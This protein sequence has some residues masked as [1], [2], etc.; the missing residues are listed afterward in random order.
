MASNPFDQFDKEVE[1]STGGANPFDKFDEKELTVG[2][3][4]ELLSRGAA[5]V[6]TGAV[7]G[8]PFGA[9]GSLV[10]SMAVPIGDALNTI[11]NELSKGNAAVENYIRGLVGVEQTAKPIQLPMVSTLVSKGMEKVG[12]GAEPTTTEERVIEAGGGGFGGA[13][14]QLAALNRMEIGRAHV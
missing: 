2:R 8:S 6:V 9:A 4:G 3:V 11:V 12:L 10:G 13:S 5:P 1:S 7:A 14:S